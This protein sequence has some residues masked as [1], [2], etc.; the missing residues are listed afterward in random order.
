M[1]LKNTAIMIG[2][3]TLV[4]WLYTSLLQPAIASWTDPAMTYGFPIV[5]AAIVAVLFT[6]IF[7]MVNKAV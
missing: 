6:Y 3:M 7:K 1:D 4:L 2:V 5:M